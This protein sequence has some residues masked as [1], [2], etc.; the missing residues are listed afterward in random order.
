[1]DVLENKIKNSPWFR[2]PN[3]S[4]LNKLDN[5]SLLLEIGRASRNKYVYIV[6]NFNCKNIN[7]DGEVGDIESE[8]FLSILQ[9]NFLKQVITQPRRVLTFRTQS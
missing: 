6:R 1:M 2:A 7:C 3:L 8:D 4:N 9:H 5:G